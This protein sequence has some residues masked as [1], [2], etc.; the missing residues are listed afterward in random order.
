MHL[1]TFSHSLLPLSNMRKT[2]VTSV[3]S[4]FTTEHRYLLPLRHAVL[5]LTVSYLQL[6]RSFFSFPVSPASKL[7]SGF[8]A[9]LGSFVGLSIITTPALCRSGSAAALCC[10][11]FWSQATLLGA[12]SRNLR[13]VKVFSCNLES[14]GRQASSHDAWM[15]WAFW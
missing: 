11:A 4:S 2:S 7:P 5:F 15:L 14:S 13:P 6:R 12:N 1:R 9:T 8:A 10:L 3:A